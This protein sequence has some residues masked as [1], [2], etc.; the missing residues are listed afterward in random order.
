V[1]GA[2]AAAAQSGYDHSMAWVGGPDGDLASA[3]ADTARADSI[4]FRNSWQR[5]QFC[6]YVASGAGPRLSRSYQK[7][8]NMPP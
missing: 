4:N 3:A 8:R 6:D 7:G 2:C 1:A 5:R